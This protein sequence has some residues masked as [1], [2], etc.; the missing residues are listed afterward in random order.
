RLSIKQNDGQDNWFRRRRNE[1]FADG[2]LVFMLKGVFAN[3]KQPIAN[4]SIDDSLKRHGLAV[5]IK[6]VI[7]ALQGIGLNDVETVCDQ[8]GINSAAI[9]YLLETT[10]IFCKQNNQENQYAVFLVNN[11]E[12][13]P[14][15][16]PPHLLKEI[17]NNLFERNAILQWQKGR[18]IAL[19][20]GFC[21]IGLQNVIQTY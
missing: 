12:V 16:D 7:T 13:I 2:A 5:K 11:H 10:V 19:S 17:R 4:Y 9:K 14:L 1:K 3:W 6:V 20:N 21:R 18:Q 15:S 8:V